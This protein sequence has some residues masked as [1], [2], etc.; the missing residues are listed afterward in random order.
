MKILL[1]T[2]TFM[3]FTGCSCSTITE[4]EKVLGTA[5]KNP[6]QR[7]CRL[8]REPVEVKGVYCVTYKGPENLNEKG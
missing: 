3:L 7:V 2:V 4:S 5:K 6:E 8:V 1:A